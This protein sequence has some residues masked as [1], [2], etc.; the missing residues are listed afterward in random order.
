MTGLARGIVSE[1]ASRVSDANGLNDIQF[2]PVV[3]ELDLA[4]VQVVSAYTDEIFYSILTALIG[5]LRH[6]QNLINEMRSKCLAVACTGWLSLGRVLKWLVSN[7]VVLIEYLDAK[8]LSC[9]PSVSW[10]LSLFSMTPVMNQLDI[11]FKAI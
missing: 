10:W 11:L 4:V 3:H 2:W 7:R 8:G 9:K 1:I 5:Y 6:Q